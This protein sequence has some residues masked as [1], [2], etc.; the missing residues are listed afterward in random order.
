MAAE[1]RE[2]ALVGRRR[3]T[4]PASRCRRGS[5]WRARR[6]R[7]PSS[8]PPAARVTASVI[9]RP[10]CVVISKGIAAIAVSPIRSKED[11]R[12]LRHQARRRRSAGTSSP[13]QA[14]RARRPASR[15][16]R[17]TI[18][19]AERRDRA[20]RHPVGLVAVEQ[21]EDL[22]S[23]E[24]EIAREPLPASSQA[25]TI[26]S[27]TL[28]PAMLAPAAA[29]LT[30]SSGS[31]PATRGP[32]FGLTSPWA[33]FGRQEPGCR[34]SRF[35]T[36]RSAV[37]ALSPENSRLSSPKEVGCTAKFDQTPIGSPS[38][39]SARIYRHRP[40]RLQL[41]LAGRRGT[42]SLRWKASKARCW[43]PPS[44]SLVPSPTLA[45]SSEGVGLD[46]SPPRSPS[47]VMPNTRGSK[48]SPPSAW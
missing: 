37:A 45:G 1:E 43:R 30:Y 11:R 12:R 40:V 24:L 25:A 28:I 5:R 23:L 20:D 42:S 48:K 35:S 18:P 19:G 4:P 22:V 36:S 27:A 13:A 33:P 47:A 14:P 21:P 39:A 26:P 10:I 8:S 15:S 32:P 44:S 6:S 16:P 3:R 34:R 17:R 29:L 2:A 46:G 38:A 9:R 31:P 41:L 7:A